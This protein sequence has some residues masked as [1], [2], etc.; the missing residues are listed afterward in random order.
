M[1]LKSGYHHI[2]I[3][4]GDEWKKAIKT[5]QDL[6]E[7]LVMPFGMSNAPSTFMRLMTEVLKPL[8]KDCVVVY[9]DYILIFRKTRKAHL[10]DVIKVMKILAEHQLKL[11]VQKC[12]FLVYEVNFLGYVVGSQG[13]KVD[14][15]KMDTFT[16]WMTPSNL[17]EV[18]SFLGLPSFYRRFIRNLSTTASPTTDYLKK[19]KFLWT[20]EAEK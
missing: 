10:K 6:Y 5:D 14:T 7:W 8:L 13:M 18:K 3:R 12:E 15:K 4:E 17:T 9:F 2:R 19:G 20:P 1:D 11:N 16:D